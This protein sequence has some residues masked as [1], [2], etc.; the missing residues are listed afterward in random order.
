[1]GVIIRQGIKQTAIQ[2]LGIGFGAINL[3]FVYTLTLS[4]DELGFM[5]FL[6]TAS[7]L[8]IPFVMLGVA[9]LINYAFPQFRDDEKGHHGFLFWMMALTGMGLLSFFMLYFIFED[10]IPHW[11]VEQQFYLEMYGR[12]FLPWLA[13]YALSTVLLRHAFN[14]HRAAIPVAFYD[15][16]PKLAV[17]VVCFA[18]YFGL[19]T[20]EGVLTG[21]VLIHV[22]M[23]LGLLWYVYSL[24]QLKLKP[25]FSFFQQGGFRELGTFALYSIPGSL[26]SSIVIYLDTIMVSALTGF[27]N[28]AIYTIPN[29]VTSTM[30]VPRRSIASISTP[31]IT[32]AW[33][34][35]DMVE[36]QKLYE[37]SSINQLIPGLLILIGVWCC[38][39]DLYAI[40]PEDKIGPTFSSGKY[41]VLILGAGRLVDL[42]T[43]LNS[44]VISFSPHY[45]VNFIALVVLM[46]LAL[47]LNFLLIPPFGIEGAA[48]A[49]MISLVIFNAIKYFYL[50]LKFNLQPLTVEMWY[51]LG[52]GIAAFASGYFIPDILHPLLTI[53]VKAVVITSVYA[54]LIYWTKASHEVN[55]L[56]DGF[57]GRFRK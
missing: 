38:I 35:G 11:F 53:A 21:Q 17:P 23:F 36:I 57:L 22:A 37:R 10:T 55:T 50:L 6:I 24:G 54:G 40:I 29:F 18:Y 51:V 56:V 3:L 20:F 34:R 46:I 42:I 12:L 28:T 41:V 30:D 32:D 16:W 52:C 5:Q 44:E 31:I 27:T 7:K 14:F 48:F 43:G 8:L 1:M 26:G 2:V 33:N 39:D 15:L 25:V 9:F 4:K 45:R 49:T 13:F 19:T 47:G